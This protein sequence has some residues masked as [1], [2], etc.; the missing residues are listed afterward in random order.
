MQESDHRVEGG[1]AAMQRILRSGIPPTAVLA[2]NDLTAIGAIGA[3]HEAGLQVPED[4][5]VIGF[6][7]IEL[8]AYIQ[9]GL[10]TLQVPRRE[11]AATAFRTLYRDRDEVAHTS[12]IKWEHVIQPRL[13]VR[14][15]TAQASEPITRHATGV[16]RKK[17]RVRAR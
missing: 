16:G 13:I 12:T 2:S 4:I 3:I 5:S 17:K 14:H 7:D 1:H 8:S 10:T 6:D 9:P 11:L 15:S